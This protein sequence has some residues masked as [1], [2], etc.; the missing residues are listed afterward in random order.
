MTSQT[1]ILL[2]PLDFVMD[3]QDGLLG[4]R[5]LS[6]IDQRLFPL[7]ARKD[8][9]L[10]EH[11]LA[12]PPIWWVC[13]EER[14]REPIMPSS[15]SRDSSCT[16]AGEATRTGFVGRG[17]GRLGRMRGTTTPQ[18]TQGWKRMPFPPPRAR[19]EMPW[20]LARQTRNTMPLHGRRQLLA[21]AMVVVPPQAVH[22]I[23]NVAEPISAPPGLNVP[24]EDIHRRVRRRKRYAGRGLV[25]AGI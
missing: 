21:A 7:M 22:A 19:H 20:Q 25:L 6:G 17:S 12:E 13:G 1:G 14:E 8:V 5:K 16:A 4:G 24:I 23:G 15:S 9:R 18:L 10:V 3:E 2:L 11:V